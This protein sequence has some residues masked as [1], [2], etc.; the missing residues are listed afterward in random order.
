MN[1]LTFAHRHLEWIAAAIIVLALSFAASLD[2]RYA[3]A[4]PAPDPIAYVPGMRVATASPVSVATAVS[5]YNSIAPS[6]DPATAAPSSCDANVGKRNAYVRELARSLPADAD[7]I[8]KYVHDNVAFAP[9]FG[10]KKGAGGAILDGDGTAADQAQLLIEL[11]RANGL[12][13]RYVFGTA[14]ATLA[15]AQTW[16][17]VVDL[18]SAERLFADGGIPVERTATA[19]RFAHVWVELYG[20]TGTTAYDPSFKRRAPSTDAVDIA[21]ALGI[22]SSA[23]RTALGG[24][25]DADAN[26]VFN[27]TSGLD[28]YLTPKA[29]A[30]AM[31]LFKNEQ[32]SGLPTSMQSIDFATLSFEDLLGVGKVL[33]YGAT[34]V[35]AAMRQPL[36]Y[37]QTHQH[38][39][40][41]PE[42][43][44]ATVLIQIGVAE[45]ANSVM[46]WVMTTAL[47]LSVVANGRIEV[48]S[49]FAGSPQ[50]A[51]ETG[52]GKVQLYLDGKEYLSSGDLPVWKEHA[53]WFAAI[54]TNLPY[55]GSVD[56][57]AGSYGDDMV[58]AKLDVRSTSVLFATA[59]QTSSRRLIE[60][61]RQPI[62]EAGRFLTRNAWLNGSPGL[63]EL[64]C[65]ADPGGSA[66]GWAFKKVGSVGS[67]LTCS[68]IPV[69]WEP[70][71]LSMETGSSSGGGSCIIDI[72]APSTPETI[73]WPDQ[74]MPCAIM[75]AGPATVDSAPNGIYPS[76]ARAKQIL[77][78][79]YLA[80]ES[81]LR[82]AG[83]GLSNS[84]MQAHLLVG[85]VSSAI[86]VDAYY[87]VVSSDT[88]R[89]HVEPTLSTNTRQNLPVSDQAIS[90]KT[91]LSVYSSAT[92]ALEGSLLRTS[93][94]QPFDNS[95]AGKFRWAIDFDISGA[96][97]PTGNKAVEDFRDVNVDPEGRFLRVTPAQYAAQGS[98]IWNST[99]GYWGPIRSAV[100]AR[101]AQGYIAILPKLGTLGP[102]MLAQQRRQRPS[103]YTEQQWYENVYRRG[104]AAVVLIDP[105]TGAVAH[106]V[107]GD[108]GG[109]FKGGTSGPELTAPTIV[110]PQSSDVNSAVE[111]WS[112]LYQVD[113][114]D[115]RL[116]FD[117][118]AELSMGIDGAGLEYR[119]TY[120]SERA[121]MDRQQNGWSDNFQGWLALGSGALGHFG[122]SRP[123][124]A[125]GMLTAIAAATKLL[126]NANDVDAVVGSE[127][128]MGWWTERLMFANATV[129]QGAEELQFY[130]A[131]NGTFLP[132]TPRGGQLKQT[133]AVTVG[134]TLIPFQNALLPGFQGPGQYNSLRVGFRYDK[135]QVSFAYRSADGEARRF[136]YLA[137]FYPQSVE[138]DAV[139]P[140]SQAAFLPNCDPGS[141]YCE[142]EGDGPSDAFRLSETRTQCPVGAIDNI[143][144]CA[145]RTL[146][147]TGGDVADDL[148]NT[149]TRTIALGGWQSGVSQAGRTL[150]FVG[151]SRAIG[152]GGTRNDMLTAVR[153]KDTTGNVVWE[154]KFS[155]VNAHG[156][157]VTS[158]FR[159]LLEKVWF[160]HDHTNPYV[161]F[162]YTDDDR[163][164]SVTR[165][166]NK[167][168]NYL[169]TGHRTEVH[170]PTGV[171]AVAYY[172]DSGRLF[173]AVDRIGR[174]NEYIHD[175]AGR[176]I[177][178]RLR[179]KTDP[180]SVYSERTAYKA[181]VY[182][183]ITEIIVYPRT[184]SS[185]TP[186]GSVNIVAKGEY[187]NANWPL[188]ITKEIDALGRA[189]FYT[190][191]SYG[192]LVRA[193]GASGERTDLS[194]DAKGFQTESR[195]YVSESVYRAVDF[196][197]TAGGTSHRG[198]IR[199]ASLY[200]SS[201]PANR[202][203]TSFVWNS[204]GDLVE[205][206][207]PR[208][209]AKAA[210]YDAARRTTEYRHYEG[211]SSGQPR[212][213]RAFEYDL[214]GRLT[215]TKAAKDAVG[216]NWV[217]TSA[218][219][220]ASGQV[221][222]IVD[223]DLDETTFAYDDRDWLATAA[224]G[225]GRLTSYSYDNAGR[226]I[227][228]KRGVG[229]SLAQAYRSLTYSIFDKPTRLR[230]AKGSD[231][232]C[233]QT[234]T[235]YDT[236]YSFDE[237]GR[238][239]STEYPDGT[240]AVVTLNV[241]D[242]IVAL[243]TRANE[244]LNY[245]YDSSSREIARTTP[246]GLYNF[247][248]DREGKRVSAAFAPVSGAQVA[249]SY[250]YD[251]FGRV[252]AERSEDG[253][254]VH[255]EYDNSN[256]LAAI[257]WPDG[258]RAEY[259][260]NGLN[261]LVEIRGGTP[262]AIVVIARY[263]YDF[264]GRRTE[265][266]FGSATGTPVSS[267]SYSYED[268]D[269][270]VRLE[271]RFNSGAMIKVLRHS[272]DK[273]GK[274][275]ATAANDSSWM[276]TSPGTD[277][278]TR[279]YASNS[280]DQYTSVTTA[281]TSTNIA[282]D[283]NGN[284][285]SDGVWTFGYDA[286]NRLLSAT[287]PGAIV[288]YSYDAVGR[289]RTKSVNGTVTRYLTA[290]D[291]E[292]AEYNE[293]GNLLRRYIPGPGIDEPIATITGTGS[294]LSIRYMHSDRQHSIVALADEAGALIEGP[295]AYD[296]YGNSTQ[297][298]GVPYRYSG[299]RL[300]PETGLYYYRARYYSPS[301]GRFLQTDPIG[302][303]DS[304]NLYA[305]AGGD[306]LNASD[307]FGTRGEYKPPATQKPP[308]VVIPGRGAVPW[309]VKVVRAGG[310]GFVAAIFWYFDANSLNESEDAMLEARY[311]RHGYYQ[312]NGIPNSVWSM[313][314]HDR[315]FMIG[316]RR[317]ENLP[318]NYPGIDVWDA[319]TQTGTSI[320]SI[321]LR[322]RTYQDHRALE[323]RIKGYV[324]DLDAFNGAVSHGINT[325]G[326]KKKRLD[327]VVP[328]GATKDQRLAIARARQYGKSKGIEVVVTETER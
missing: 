210:S 96:P 106:L 208:G 8:F 145:G 321:D 307:P 314:N 253:L 98:A 267:I 259:I 322:A 328:A 188:Q 16:L 40:E 81:R 166:G 272:Y 120:R 295:F 5:Y 326:I 302:Y 282:Y 7:E 91:V 225:E 239:K 317:G 152:A 108:D 125:A 273:S 84:I 103:D 250:E 300:D 228:E 233:A 150:E 133:G 141:T 177:E 85:V 163:I 158:E 205:V 170:D 305:Y 263:A 79:E 304:A 64:V 212:A 264:L 168:Y 161:K 313:S 254:D 315:G 325:T 249:T 138:S 18:E 135:S 181:D 271:H 65:K 115:G 149:V 200:L 164:D 238:D 123:A 285:L 94:G 222:K 24:T 146:T 127:L 318:P 176:V 44:S 236:L 67:S 142:P 42:R 247:S 93:F 308:T 301:L 99:V 14:E 114:R 48:R 215:H 154:Y 100:E 229:T 70:N 151:S 230:S 206:T 211:P 72:Y 87:N 221:S 53:P 92:S 121:A 316:A 73:H 112:K 143:A 37:T 46:N 25:G 101:L 39:Y 55:A 6:T 17:G 226:L 77:A 311:Q 148:G 156:A 107:A 20:P 309:Y 29:Q 265:L 261:R 82:L 9:T 179:M 137:A 223:P 198:L 45:G 97:S 214:S 256:N 56:S 41:V 276:P 252:L 191:D 34:P 31:L 193:D 190:V 131:P 105:S 218:S 89:I 220:T 291:E 59:G 248:Y 260:H 169:A 324:D 21:A 183:N 74:L 293:A 266:A 113:D 199:E 189:V 241:A 227:C 36:S 23:L 277:L 268:D 71:S 202:Q 240:A 52:T 270:L 75:D 147:F 157:G 132:E 320:K 109:V 28:N 175:G 274:L 134:R 292:I 288:T 19:I 237:Y 234:S 160:P 197:Y 26:R 155:Y 90:R 51:Q 294:S 43:F 280:L 140:V 251:N 217:S 194:Y 32:P 319:S 201:A 35:S 255:Y 219:Y 287:K 165:A 129:V 303:E 296:P 203:T 186:M 192:R 13:A 299:R 69:N 245:A 38:W 130:R 184:D 216:S 10:L 242:E 136:D 139:G 102:E 110:R 60:F 124:H 68:V 49:T 50:A 224:D 312:R 207:D 284:L 286:E 204:I 306:P 209:N 2:W 275:K 63:N 258:F 289:R 126:T 187:G 30:L 159:P 11:L 12:C 173:H 310:S 144:L 281:G 279:T 86:E 66:S 323:R 327:I 128:A 269:D 196:S 83:G 213:R 62:D 116:T 298:G 167:V 180:I 3:H 171:A 117:L 80:R 283:Q 111:P 162:A 153:L 1:I 278:N 88:W 297:S 104:S 122:V 174:L 27:S 232:A 76:G 231:A 185:G 246:S 54:T 4:Q 119:L 58:L 244:A 172:D 235:A 195:T 33:P 182:D 243:K 290:G 57:V 61:Q 118:P 257:V 262:G 78:L 178:T 15:Q 95:L 22:T 47:P